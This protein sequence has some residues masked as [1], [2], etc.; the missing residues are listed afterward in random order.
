E[1]VFGWAKHALG[2]R[3]FLLRGLR[4]VNGEWNLVCTALNLRRMRAALA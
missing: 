1:P 4:K 3:A 2:F